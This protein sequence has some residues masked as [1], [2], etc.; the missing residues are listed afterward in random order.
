VGGL[1][2][3]A[4]A[5]ASPEAASSVG[6]VTLQ[7]GS[8]TLTFVVTGKDPRSTGYLAGV[9]YVTLNPLS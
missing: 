1:N 7:P 8:H 9:D 4:P 3:Y 5:L 6:T 2:S